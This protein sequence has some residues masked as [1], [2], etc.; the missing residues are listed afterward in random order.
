MWTPDV[1][2]GAPTPITTFMSTGTKT[3]AMGAFLL[4]FTGAAQGAIA[5]WRV[6]IGAISAASMVVGNIG[7]LRQ[8]SVKRMLAWS[9]V[10]QA[11]YLLMGV[12]VGTAFGAEALIYYLIAY[13]AM[14]LAAFAIVILREREVEDGDQLEAFTGY[15]RRRPWAGVVMTLAM[16]SLAGFPPLAGFIG[17][18]LL[19]SA[20]IDN[21]ML[22][23]AIVGALASAVSVVY[24][25]RVSIVMWSPAPVRDV[26]ERTRSPPWPWRV[27]W[28]LSRWPSGR[29][30]S[31]TCAATPG[32]RSFPSRPQD[33]RRSGQAGRRPG[34]TAS[35]TSAAMSS[36]RCCCQIS[37]WMTSG[38]SSNCVER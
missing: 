19:F 6:L 7:A 21:D 22:W 37:P 12:A 33:G 5:D 15:G 31:S 1:Y 8:T 10:A 9:S 3:A 26:A 34:S 35:T 13:L 24:Y 14:T 2:E 23:L 27:A 11:G 20:A 32:H 36:L 25:L 16:L 4:V 18:F 29:S 38:P 17:K 30:R 28:P